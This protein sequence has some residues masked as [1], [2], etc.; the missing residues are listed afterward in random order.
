[1]LEVSS[2]NQNKKNN[3]IPDE[4]FKR[5]AELICQVEK[6][7]T[8]KQKEELKSMQLLGD[9]YLI[10]N[11]KYNIVLRCPYTGKHFGRADHFKKHNIDKEEFK[12]EYGGTSVIEMVAN[13]I[14]YFYRPNKNKWLEQNEICFYDYSTEKQK[15][16]TNKANEEG[17]FSFFNWY[18]NI[19]LIKS[20]L[21]KKKTISIFAKNEKASWIT[22]DVDTGGTAL[23]D[24]EK[25][26]DTMINYGIPRKDILVT[27][28]GGKGY[29][30]EIFFKF[31]L[32]KKYIRYFGEKI[33]YLSGYDINQKYKSGKIELFPIKDT[34]IKLP[35]GI[36]QKTSKLTRVLNEQMEYFDFV[37]QDY[38]YFL[39][40]DRIN[41]DLIW[42]IIKYKD[43]PDESE[44]QNEEKQ[45]A[46]NE[47]ISE[48]EYDSEEIIQFKLIPSLDARIKAIENKFKNGLTS[49]NTHHYLAFQIGLW[50]WEILKWDRDT[51]EE[52]L[53]KW[54]EKNLE[55]CKTKRGSIHDTKQVIKSLW[56]KPHNYS[57][58]DGLKERILNF[59]P[60]EIKLVKKIQKQAKKERKRTLTNAPSLLYFTFLCM[61]KYFGKSTY[62]IG[63]KEL[64][65][66]SKLADKTFYK[67]YY[68]L[69]DKG[70]IQITNKG[71]SYTGKNTEYY[72]PLLDND[73]KKD[74][75]IKITINLNNQINI[76]D[77]Y[78]KLI[79]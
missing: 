31:P 14:M 54:T 70:Y 35:L 34:A 77:I 39:S 13:K 37:Y 60:E 79:I 69:L 9:D 20:H 46:K 44:Q 56:D 57:L 33:C 71:N 38:I 55:F 8:K 63:I 49:E 66:Y 64:Y 45:N 43:K 19:Q 36:N 72:I 22:F 15:E 68:W 30:I 32:E 78:N 40:V 6:R 7:L 17:K 48:N 61:G 11:K 4:S 12:F 75:M 51:A 26:V 28:S 27:F 23:A 10:N 41:N 58:S 74:K 52:A 18:V 67:W 62:N 2:N 59:Y 1:M 42:S 47:D 73:Y 29:H 3:Y 25:I 21:N 76:K 16:K 65:K 5:G 53:I 50:M 24:T